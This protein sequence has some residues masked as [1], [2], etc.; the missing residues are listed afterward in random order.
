[1]TGRPAPL[2]LGAVKTWRSAGG[3][4]LP[5][6]LVAS[7][8]LGLVM[9]GTMG[10]LQSTLRAYRWGAARVEAQQSARVAIERIVKELRDAGYDPRA[11]GIDAI[12][13]AEPAR[14]VFQRDLDGDGLVDPTS[15][16]VAFLLRS[17]ESVLRRDAGAGA[18]PIVTDVRRFA[19]TYF[20]SAGRPTADPAA[21]AAIQVEI[22]VGPADP[23]VIM[24]TRVS[25]R[26][27]RG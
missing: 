12:V 26:N 14:V 27:R 10:L 7:A 5:E 23:P 9:A 8:V 13:A 2:T 21:V 17:G 20:D 3:Y 15:E 6:V 4:S 19:L 25:L 1:L 18:Q 24:Q 16:R 22:E 11:A